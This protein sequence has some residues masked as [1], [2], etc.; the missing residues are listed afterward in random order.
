M[1]SFAHIS[2]CHL[3]ANRDPFLRSLEI[4]AFN[5]AMDEC[6]RR[7]VDFVLITGDLFHSNIPDLGVANEAVK[8]MSEVAASGIPIYVIYGS[9]DYSPNE[10]SLV[11]ILSSAN[12]FRKVVRGE[13]KNGKLKLH[14]FQDPKTGA[15]IAGI[16]AR[17][18]GI[19]RKYFE[20]LDR[21]SLEKEPGFKIFAFHSAVTELKPDYLTH[22][23]SVPLSYFPRGFNYLA[24]GHIHQH[25]IRKVDGYGTVAYPGAL[26]A[27]Y[28]RDLEDTAKGVRRGF[29]IVSF[30][31]DVENVE[32]VEVP[33]PEYLYFEYDATG[34]N[35][36]RVA[37]D[38]ETKAGELPV[39]NRIVLMKIAGE[40]SGGNTSDINFMELRNTLM[41]R[42][43]LY[44]GINRHG[45]TT[46]EYGA[47]TTMAEDVGEV[48]RKLFR[49][50]IGAV[51]VSVDSLRGDAGAKLAVELLSVLRQSQKAGETKKDYEA[52]MLREAIHLLKLEEAFQG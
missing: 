3:G 47:V 23:V 43:A 51:K 39:E 10:T 33:G 20:M 40:M 11:D 21:E 9:H 14:F 2:D 7:R 17:R 36:T 19:E 16:S 41:R 12:L 49:E 48:E 45:L 31:D 29:L 5:R 18:L 46:R 27:G 28:P 50:N 13:V 22:M 44:V 34:K 15:K 6:V 25:L 52:R 35:S 1:Y 4:E 38:L 8:K 32:F 37:E 30:R 24:G 42:G 26:F